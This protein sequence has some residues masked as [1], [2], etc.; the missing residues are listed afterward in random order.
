MAQKGRR[1]YILLEEGKITDVW[2]NLKHL[3]ED[4]DKET[5][6]QFASYSKLAKMDKQ[7]GILSFSGKNDVSYIIKIKPIR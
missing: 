2:S 5:N 6:Q 4:M 1:I 7:E 3:C